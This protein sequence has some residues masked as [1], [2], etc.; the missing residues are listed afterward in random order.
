LEAGYRFH[1]ACAAALAGC[2]V[3]QDIARLDE[4][5]R[6]GLRNRALDWLTAEQSAW[7]ERHRRGQ[8]GDRTAAA[9]ALRSWQENE[10]LAG[11]RGEQALSRLP[12]DERRD[13]Q[14]LWAKVSEVAEADPAAL[15]QRARVH[16]ARGEWAKASEC[17]ARGF[18][19]GPRD[20]GDLW[21][22]HAAVQLLAGEQTGYRRTCEEM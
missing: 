12:A 9:T 21:F 16:I 6:A 19:L 13:W 1:A 3:G 7:A 18:A 20:D 2:G 11:V 17:Y 22:E 15:F 14:A 5:Q 10:D 8:P 4:R